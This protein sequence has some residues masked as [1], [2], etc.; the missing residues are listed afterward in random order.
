MEEQ[1]KEQPKDH[2]KILAAWDFPEF[3]EYRRSKTWYIVALVILAGLLI[4]GFA[5]NNYLFVVLI[6]IFVVI[7]VMRSRRKPA[8]LDFKITE[9]GIA[10]G[11]EM[12][13]EWKQLKSFWIVYEPPEVKNL[14]FDFKTG[15]R[16]SLTILLGDQNP[17]TVRKILLEY[18]KEDTEKENETFTD[19]VSRLL[20]L[21]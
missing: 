4:F 20:K 10:I 7:Y 19:S 8:R 17:L 18:L 13:Y 6:M 12:F 16:P 1:T 2:G 15:I 3:R 21:Q 5:S 9:D 14:Y 11:T